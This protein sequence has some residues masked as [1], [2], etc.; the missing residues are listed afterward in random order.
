MTSP[1]LM[2]LLAVAAAVC[3]YCRKEPE[4]NPAPEPPQFEC[5]VYYDD[6]IIH[7]LYQGSCVDAGVTLENID[8]SPTQARVYASK[9]IERVFLLYFNN[10]CSIGPAWLDQQYLL[11]DGS[12]VVPLPP[13]FYN[14][15]F[16]PAANSLGHAVWDVSMVVYCREK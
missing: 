16:L 10:E 6:C 15:C 1:N 7:P 8:V 9:P 11:P 4:R 5:S 13:G 2:L 3:T 12:C 14:E